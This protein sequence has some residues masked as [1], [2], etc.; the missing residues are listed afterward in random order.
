MSPYRFPGMVACSVMAAGI[1]LASMLSGPALAQ[2]VIKVG[3]PLPLTGPLSPE[4]HQAAARLQSLGRSRQRQGRHQGRRQ[5][6]QGRDRLRR[7][8]VEHARARCRSAERLITEDKVQFPVLRRSARARPRPRARSRRSTRS[9]C[10]R[11]RHPRRRSSTRNIKYLFGDAYRQRDRARSRIAKLVDR[12]EQGDQA[13]RDP[14]PQRSV[15][16]RDRAGDGEGGQGRGH[17]GRHVR[18]LRHRRA[19]S[20]GSDHPDARRQPGLGL[21]R[22]ATSTT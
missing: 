4:G 15:P 14:R 5:D 12:Q 2:D 17:G 16:A 7:L 20:F 1:A 8:R 11:R 13:G 22:P 21:S 9:R 6:L 19:R 3:A 18:A 10:S